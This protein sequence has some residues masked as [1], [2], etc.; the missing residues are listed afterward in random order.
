M[1]E[2]PIKKTAIYSGSAIGLFIAGTAVKSVVPKYNWVGWILQ[3]AT[4]IPVGMLGLLLYEYFKEFE[5]PF[6]T[7][8]LGVL[9]QI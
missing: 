5:L 9:A 1:T 4:V 6:S 3:I 7:E 8:E 2:F